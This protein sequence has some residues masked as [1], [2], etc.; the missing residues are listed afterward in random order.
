MGRAGRESDPGLQVLGVV[1]GG[2]PMVINSVNTSKPHYQSSRVMVKTLEDLTDTLQRQHFLLRKD[3]ESILNSQV[4]DLG[5]E[6]VA[7]ILH[8]PHAI[9]FT[10]PD[11]IM[12]VE[13]SLG[14]GKDVYVSTVR[15][16]GEAIFDIAERLAG[17]PSTAGKGAKGTGR[18]RAWGNRQLITSAS[19]RRDF[20]RLLERL[21]YTTVLLARLRV[22]IKPEREAGL[23]GGIAGT[24][25]RPGSRGSNANANAHPSLDSHGNANVLSRAAERLYTAISAG[26]DSACHATHTA[27]LFLPSGMELRKRGQEDAAKQPAVFMVG[28]RMPSII[29]G[30]YTV[31]ATVIPNKASNSQPIPGP[32]SGRVSNDLCQL[33]TAAEE[34]GRMLEVH[35]SQAG[36]CTWNELHPALSP[37]RTPAAADLTTL[38]TVIRHS[39]PGSWTT[40]QKLRLSFFLASSILQLSP[41]RWILPSHPL[42]SD[43]I[44]F[45]KA[46]ASTLTRASTSAS[47]LP[48]K[49]LI[50][51][52]FFGGD[53]RPSE[54]P[55][56]RNSLL[57]FT[58]LLLEIW[59][60]RTFDWYAEEIQAPLDTDFWAR[61]RIVEMW[62]EDSKDLVLD[63][64]Y[65]IM[66]RCV[67][68]TFG[69]AA[70]EPV[71][72]WDD[73]V[74]RADFWRRVVVVLGEALDAV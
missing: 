49:P 52:D 23:T 21:D 37:S 7:E 46:N 41:T 2:L 71:A 31:E 14:D 55:V 28:F 10:E 11:V 63:K 50:L 4:G 74:F 15:K 72:R 45:S 35:V 47:L 29:K 33:V 12:A 20:D 40:A 19:Q 69:T 27:A 51:R 1:I 6:R 65:T 30:Y 73:D 57:E 67:N 61:L 17:F 62:V 68:G 18:G 5:E 34:Q 16:C 26:F 44:W 42:T 54:P 59:H 38:N 9:Y 13:R 64:V 66:V 53:T 39:A 8:Q 32:S 60:Q 56:A 22:T 24:A 58:V 48:P 70:T 43:T 36:S 3:L 25:S